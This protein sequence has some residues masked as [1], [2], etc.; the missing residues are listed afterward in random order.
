MNTAYFRVKFLKKV[1][2]T[3][4]SDPGVSNC[5]TFVHPS[6][7][8]SLCVYNYVGVCVFACARVCVVRLFTLLL[9]HN[10]ITVCVYMSVSRCVRMRAHAS[11]RRARACVYVFL[12]SL[13]GWGWGDLSV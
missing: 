5:G 10:N 7:S 4:V 1:E 13:G 12:F 8:S 11:V 9:P 2:G 6:S 3:T